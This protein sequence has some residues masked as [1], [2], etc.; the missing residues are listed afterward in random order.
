MV[1]G[2]G[3]TINVSAPADGGNAGI[4]NVSAKSGGFD[5]MGTIR[6]SAGGDRRTGSFTLDA[7]TVPG[8]MLGAIDAT[9]NEGSFTE[10]R[11]Y[12]LRTGNV[13]VDGVGARP[14]LPRHR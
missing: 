9:L 6:G 11:E 10:A 1:V 8:G 14:P 7:A 3:G 12:R 2:A 4:I 5:L 13:T